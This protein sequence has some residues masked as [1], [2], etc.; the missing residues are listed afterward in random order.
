[1]YYMNVY[2]LYMHI[3]I[4]IENLY[5]HQHPFIRATSRHE[6]QLQQ[7]DTKQISS[8]QRPFESQ[9]SNSQKYYGTS[10]FTAAKTSTFIHFT[11]PKDPKI[12]LSSV[13]KSLSNSM[14]YWLVKIGIPLLDYEVIPNILGSIIN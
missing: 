11:A 3:Y 5:T 14:K 6:T 10:K 8:N 2:V 9:Y 13:Q 4:Y 7:F 12:K 1:M